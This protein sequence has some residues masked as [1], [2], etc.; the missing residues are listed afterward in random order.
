MRI[1]LSFLLIAVLF[2]FSCGKKK[3]V[4]STYAGNGAMAY[5]D[6]KSTDASFSNLMGLALDA[7]GNVYVADSRNNLI[8]KIS[9][10]G[11]VTTL[12]GSG[13]IG[14]ADGKAGAASFFNPVA[15][16]ADKNGNVYVADT[17]NSLI[18]KIGPDGTVTTLAGRPVAKNKRPIF[19]NPMAITTDAAGNIFIAD[20]IHDQV[21]EISPDGKVTT[22]AGSG[23]PGAKDGKG[24]A[25]S[26]YLPEG[27]AAD[28]KGNLYVS[29]TYNN[30][31][32]KVDKEWGGYHIVSR[33]T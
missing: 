14:S 8:R 11:M 6:G 30:L 9:P 5:K 24:M 15:I 7:K 27:I 10:D 23:D 29:D 18:R 17:H 26:F 32:R 33:K 12:A 22:V 28:D 2:I 3:P 25:A 21:R 13:S 16:T 4:V 1:N 20:W 31:I 19:D